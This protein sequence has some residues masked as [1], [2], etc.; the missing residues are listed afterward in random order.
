M[1][2]YRCFANRPLVRHRCLDY[3]RA[4]PFS[5]RVARF[6]LAKLWPGGRNVH[7]GAAREVAGLTDEDVRSG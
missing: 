1:T 3:R 7:M 4:V 2:L 5:K 6:R